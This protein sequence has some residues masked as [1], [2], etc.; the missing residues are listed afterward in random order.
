MYKVNMNSHHSALALIFAELFILS[1]QFFGVTI[2]DLV[3]PLISDVDYYFIVL[4]ITQVAILV[5]ALAAVVIA[6][7]E[8][9]ARFKD[10]A[11]SRM[12][13]SQ[14]GRL[15]LSAI[16]L[17]FF[18][19]PFTS[20]FSELLI[21]LGVSTP[22][23]PLTFANSYEFFW[24]LILV[25]VLPAVVEEFTVRGA[26]MNGLLKVGVLP[27][28]FLSAFIFAIMHGNPYQLVHQFLLGAVMAYV[29]IVSGNLLSSF[30][31]HFTNNAIALVA[32]SL[33]YF[34]QNSP[35]GNLST[36]TA[37]PLEYV[38]L[39]VLSAL[40]A[41][42]FVVQIKRWTQGA[43]ISEVSRHPDK[44]SIYV[45]WCDSKGLFGYVSALGKWRLEVWN[46]QEK[47][48]PTI[49][50]AIGLALFI[51]GLNTYSLVVM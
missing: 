35:N 45:R 24:G 51:L 36:S 13:L 38:I 16:G 12:S 15:A 19:L 18:S 22:S 23:S 5:A 44:R 32:S 50:L 14:A 9:P 2:L 28:I 17:L 8:G 29:V 7:R 41:W 4:V 39:F 37:G 27:A 33:T 20:L 25:C 46:K 49:Y 42:L 34:A 21:N 10:F 30:I 43:I 6:R 48:S 1:L 31:M 3:A 47:L 26:I 11:P 40:G